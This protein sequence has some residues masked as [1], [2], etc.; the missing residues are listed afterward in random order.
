MVPELRKDFNE[1]YTPEHYRTLISRLD[2]EKLLCG[3][4]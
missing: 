3:L 1:R 4:P 2:L